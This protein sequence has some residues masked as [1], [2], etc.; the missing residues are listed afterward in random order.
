MPVGR[1]PV[2]P[3]LE[4]LQRQAKQLLRAIHAGDANA[5]AD[6]ASTILNSLSPP[7]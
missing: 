4:Q 3:R 2:R 1:L 6:Y 5:I 7:P